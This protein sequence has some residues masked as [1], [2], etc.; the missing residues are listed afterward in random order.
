MNLY[1]ADPAITFDDVLLVPN[2]SEI[3]PSEVDLKTR[4]TKKITLNIPMVSA[5]MD[6]VTESKMSIAIAILGGIGIIHKNLSIEKQ[7]DEVR[8]VKRSANGV[9]NDP[10]TLR[11]DETL[12][13]AYEIMREARVSGFPIVDNNKLVGILTTRDMTFETNEDTQISKIM[14]KEN[15]VTA[16]ST[17]T[18]EEA[19]NIL[20][21]EKKEKLILLNEKGELSGLITM[22]DIK[23][24]TAYPM[25]NR[26][27]SGRLI[28]G[29]AVG[30]GE[31][32]RIE[33]L[34]NANV[35]VICVDTAHGHSIKVKE[36]VEYIKSKF[37]I[38]VIAGNIATRD[39]AE[40]LIDAGVDALKVGIGPGSICTTRVVTGV[41]VPQISA[42]ESVC[43]VAHSKGV[44]VIADGGIKNSGD[45][46]KILAVGA[47]TVMLG[48]L[49]AGVEESPGSLI[50]YQG[51][52]YKEYRGMGSIGAMAQGSK[53]RYGQKGV[54][55]DKLV[56][57]GVEARVA[58]MG[59]LSDYLHQLTGGLRAGLGY[60][61]AK[62]LPDLVKKA[63]FV[64]ITQSGIRENHPHDVVIAREAPNYRVER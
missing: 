44:P 24:L 5:A 30:V 8:K 15:L 20:H 19:K 39:A 63:R 13:K 50:Y 7:A 61:G 41:G 9:I 23:N 12:K 6:T 26:D 34:V 18:L 56:P 51:R 55:S 32:E 11:P 45:I 27:E 1:Q 53:D 43:E 62:N 54:H 36:T 60:C 4:F 28:V 21:R 35:D 31:Y 42:V 22:R 37:D 64:K 49:L 29:A 46:S 40:F 48:S 16:P 59:K 25:A 14:T 47:D 33:A 58:Y 52:Q 38:Q 57:E 10:L 3:L 17:T 2:Y